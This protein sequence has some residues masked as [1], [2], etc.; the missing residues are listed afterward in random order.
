MQLK[1]QSRMRDV[2]ISAALA[3]IVAGGG[4]FFVFRLA[5]INQSTADLTGA[6]GFISNLLVNWPLLVL[7]PI[8]TALP[9]G[10]ALYLLFGLPYW[11]PVFVFLVLSLF[12]YGLARLS[13]KVL[14][15]R[16]RG[17]R[18]HAV[19]A[20]LVLVM[21]GSTVINFQS[22]AGA[23]A[24]LSGNLGDGSTELCF[25]PILEDK[26]GDKKD[27]EAALEWCL[28]FSDDDQVLLAM[29][30]LEKYRV[31]HGS[32][33]Q[34]YCVYKLGE[35]HRYANT[36]LVCDRYGQVTGDASK[37]EG[38]RVFN[39]GQLTK[40]ASRGVTVPGTGTV[41]RHDEPINFDGVDF[42]ILPLP[43]FR[44]D[45]KVEVQ[46]YG[47]KLGPVWSTNATIPIETQGPINFLTFDLEYPDR[48]TKDE[49]TLVIFLD[50]QAIGVIEGIFGLSKQGVFHRFITTK[51][52]A[53]KVR[54]RLASP[55]IKTDVAVNIRNLRFG[56]QEPYD[57]IEGEQVLIP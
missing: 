26:L 38:C 24:C 39:Q 28:S 52:G 49:T 16:D 31:P 1:S 43:E 48:S 47:L 55:S 5:L 11:W 10:L 20:I 7:L 54:F 51:E 3:L 57:V 56:L 37:A 2:V 21:I 22:E 8:L 40:S 45:T 12:F 44:E 34:D 42:G 17:Y 30:D 14:G 27:V 23:E 18:R 50:E 46:G 9:E 53:H 35:A 15:R 41:V 36:Q 13:L 32:T 29:G 6:S 33:Y 4:A 25:E 19:S